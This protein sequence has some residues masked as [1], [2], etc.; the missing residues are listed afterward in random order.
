M[1]RQAIPL[2]LLTAILAGCVDPFGAADPEEPVSQMAVDRAL[3]ESDVPALWAQGLLD[4]NLRQ[5]DVLLSDDFVLAAG[6]E[7]ATRSETYRCHQAWILAG[8]DTA[9]AALGSTVSSGG[10]S[11][12]VQVAWQLGVAGSSRSGTARWTLRQDDGGEWTLARW[13]DPAGS[14]SLLAVCRGES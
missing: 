7:T 9:S 3:D 11:A 2:A 1:V 13:L 10:D 6:T 4:G 8:I 14:A 12:V 5:V